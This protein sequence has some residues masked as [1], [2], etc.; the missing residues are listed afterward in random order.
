[1]SLMLATDRFAPDVEFAPDEL[2]GS[3]SLDRRH[4]SRVRLSRPVRVIDLQSGRHIA[5]KSRDISHSGIRVEIP[6][7]NNVRVGETIYVDVGTLSGIGPLARRPRVIPGRV[8][9][10]EREQKLLRP[11]QSVGL[12]FEA[13]D[14]ALVSV[15]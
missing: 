2:N 12:E 7:A 4:G 15:A 11:Q 1:M 3:L 13:E 8:V 6:L 5:G 10:V 14:E 9:W